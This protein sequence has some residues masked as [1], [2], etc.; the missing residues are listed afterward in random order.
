[1]PTPLREMEAELGSVKDADGGSWPVLWF[2][3]PRCNAHRC[4]VPY[5]PTGTE[6]PRGIHLVWKHVSGTTIEDITLSPSFLV[7]QPCG[8]HGWVRN[9]HWHGA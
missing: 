2:Q 7:V 4:M 5:S 9:G 1:M 8:L 3:C 6:K